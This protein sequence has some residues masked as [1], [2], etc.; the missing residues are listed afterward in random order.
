M[1]EVGSATSAPAMAVSRAFSCGLEEI[2][3][4]RLRAIAYAPKTTANWGTATKSGAV[5]PRHRPRM[6]STRTIERT[7][8]SADDEGWCCCRTLTTSKGAPTRQRQ[9][10]PMPPARSAST[11]GGFA[12]GI[13]FLQRRQE[14][15]M[16]MRAWESSVRPHSIKVLASF[17]EFLDSARAKMRRGR[18]TN[19]TGSGQ[20]LTTPPI[21]RGSTD[22]PAPRQSPAE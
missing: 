10:P 12:A 2:L 6:P 9:A 13:K 5:T 16:P 17:P 7:T 4:T 19:H 20:A 15:R 14:V 3:C 22:A 21:A 8:S 11:V 18:Q 1:N